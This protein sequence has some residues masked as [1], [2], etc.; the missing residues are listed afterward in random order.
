MGYRSYAA[1]ALILAAGMALCTPAP[2]L[3]QSG[4]TAV[5]K[6]AAAL[7]PKGWTMPRTP[8]GEPDLQGMYTNAS[9]TPQQRPADLAGKAFFTKEE[10]AAWKTRALAA[11][12]RDR[13]DGGAEADLT[14]AYNNA[15][16]DS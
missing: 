1:E 12:N 11:Q 4:L 10:A 13:R 3:A 2:V 5:E 8:D 14:R 6:A 9:L 7:A 15:F 16:Y